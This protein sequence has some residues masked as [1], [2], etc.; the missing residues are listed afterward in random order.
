[1]CLE[2]YTLLNQN[3]ISKYDPGL[4]NCKF[5][6]IGEAALFLCQFASNIIFLF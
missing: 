3:H 5:P 1:M 4:N 2:L 6:F